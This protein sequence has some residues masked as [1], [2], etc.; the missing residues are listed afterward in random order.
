MKLHHFF[1]AS[2][3]NQAKVDSFDARYDSHRQHSAA[4]E[5]IKTTNKVLIRQDSSS[6]PCTSTGADVVNLDGP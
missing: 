1:Y 3:V 6:D 4:E 2:L 5:E